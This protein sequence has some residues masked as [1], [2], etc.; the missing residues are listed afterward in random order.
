MNKSIG[1]T[2]LELITT[3]AIIGILG[4]IALPAFNN[5]I[6]QARLTSTVN[7]I[8]GSINLAKSEAID[9]NAIMAV[10]FSGTDWEIRNTVSG[11]ILRTF[12]A[13]SDDISITVA[14]GAINF[15]PNGYRTTGSP[16][17]TIDVC[18][19]DGVCRPRITISPAGRVGS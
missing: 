16:E 18:N 3:I 19:S 17:V 6:D 9:S 15:Q 2:L 4:A 10:N 5:Q 1:F 14:G 12:S 7:G 8:V 13:P 11:E